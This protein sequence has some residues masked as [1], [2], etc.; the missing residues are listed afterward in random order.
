MTSVQLNS[1]GQLVLCLTLVS[2]SRELLAHEGQLVLTRRLLLLGRED[3]LPIAFLSL[4]GISPI[5][6]NCLRGSAV[7]A[8]QSDC[9]LRTLM[10]TLKCL[11]RV[12]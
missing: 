8:M 2:E 5:Q 11:S 12:A 9:G 1:L 3:T 4:G 10:D 6:V 7:S